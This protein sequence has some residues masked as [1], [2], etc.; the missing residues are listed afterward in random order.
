MKNKLIKYIAQLKL[1]AEEKRD[2]AAFESMAGGIRC[3]GEA[4]ELE[5]VVRELEELINR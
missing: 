3:D 4:V 2:E 1:R 5:R